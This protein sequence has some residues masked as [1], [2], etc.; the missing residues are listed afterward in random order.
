MITA[1]SKGWTI[2][3][4]DVASA[5]LQGKPIDRDVFV[6]PP[7]EFCNQDK[8][9]KLNRCLYGLNDAPREWYNA[10]YEEFIKLGA[11]RSKLD[12]A[13]FMWYEGDEIIGHLCTHVD[14]FNFAGTKEWEEQVMG[15]IKSKFK[16]STEH[17]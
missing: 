1:A 11:V 16:I 9:W 14:D 4:I 5:F 13:M 17:P 12:N 15:A 6:K 3:S 7:N 8:V 2:K 10:V